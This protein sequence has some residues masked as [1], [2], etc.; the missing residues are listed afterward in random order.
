M[1]FNEHEIYKNTHKIIHIN[2][3]FKIGISS[4]FW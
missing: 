3:K 4:H 1:Y 2:I